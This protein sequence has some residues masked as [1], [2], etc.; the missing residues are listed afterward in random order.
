[1][2]DPPARGSAISR[3]GC[4]G[5]V[6]AGEVTQFRKRRIQA[7]RRLAGKYLI[8]RNAVTFE[9]LRRDVKLVPCGVKRQCADE[10]G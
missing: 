8:G 10:T 2:P 1:M 4:R 6:M 7:S 5:E 9:E 3:L